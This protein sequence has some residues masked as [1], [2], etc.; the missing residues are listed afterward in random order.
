MMAAI[1]D[2]EAHVDRAI[3]YWAALITPQEAG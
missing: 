2:F 1:I 3:M